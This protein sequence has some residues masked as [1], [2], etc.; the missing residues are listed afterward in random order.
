MS[1]SKRAT[2]SSTASS[3]R[4]CNIYSSSRRPRHDDEDEDDDP[5]SVDGDGFTGCGEEEFFDGTTC[6]PAFAPAICA[7]ASLDYY[8]LLVAC[9][10]PEPQSPGLISWRDGLGVTIPPAPLGFFF[11][12]VVG[13][14]WRIDGRAVVSDA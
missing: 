12:A 2:P 3:K 13:G 10:L 14:G 11:V 8:P 4:L 1:P 5:C 6:L 7:S 9:E